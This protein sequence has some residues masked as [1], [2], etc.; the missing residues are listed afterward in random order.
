[1]RQR[2]VSFDRISTGSTGAYAVFKIDTTVT[3][4]YGLWAKIPYLDSA[5][6]NAKHETYI[7]RYY[8]DN[9]CYQE[10]EESDDS[11][12]LT[13]ILDQSENEGAYMDSEGYEY[14]GN[15]DIQLANENEVAMVV[16]IVSC[17]NN[18]YYDDQPTYL[19][20]DAIKMVN[21]EDIE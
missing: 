17:A 20:A 15:I 4:S 16:V 3:D 13:V 5:T 19:L 14:L 7:R 10:S 21:N 2:V 12:V 9:F 18:D 1:M 6:H 11:P 8:V